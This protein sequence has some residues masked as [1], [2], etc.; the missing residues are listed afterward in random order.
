MQ[1]FTAFEYMLISAANHFGLDKEV[2]EVRLQWAKDNFKQLEVFYPQAEKPHLYRKAVMALREVCLG[3]PTHTLVQFDAVCSGMQILSVLTGCKIGAAATGLINTGK[4]PDAYTAVTAQMQEIIGEAF[5]V[6]RADAKQAVMTS[7]YGSVAE[8]EA[9]FGT[10]YKLEAF[11]AGAKKVAPG[12]F[13]M[14]E[15][16]RGTWKKMAKAQTW[17]LPDGYHTKCPVYVKTESRLQIDELGGTQVTAVYDVNVGTEKGISNVANVTHSVDAYVLRSMI[18]YC[19][20]DKN[21]VR[22]TKAMITTELAHRA[23]GGNQVGDMYSVELL[24]HY[25]ETGIVDIRLLD[26]ILHDNIMEFPTEVLKQLLKDIVTMEAYEPF[27]VVTIHDCFGCLPTNMNHVRYWYN[28]I[29]ARIAESTLTQWIFRQLFENPKLT[30]NKDCEDLGDYIRE[31]N[32][33][34][35]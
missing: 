28:E 19:S 4:R 21:H 23:N 18:R 10:G 25:E 5:T 32:Y 27:D 35:T 7:I 14:L 26:F 16:L 1:T 2:Y 13:E 9:I 22:D 30:F 17:V 6:P 11:Y 15:I 8:P 3:K 20:Y 12:A 31:A 24:N 33:S 29:L 34:L